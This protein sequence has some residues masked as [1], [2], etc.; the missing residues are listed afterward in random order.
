MIRLMGAGLSVALSQKLVIGNYEHG[1]S[2]ER[3]QAIL[4]LLAKDGITLTGK[5]S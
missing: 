1:L 4:K 5:A 2:F 3:A